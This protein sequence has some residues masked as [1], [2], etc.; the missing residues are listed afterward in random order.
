[1][2][3]RELTTYKYVIWGEGQVRG[4]IGPNRSSQ[5][6][7]RALRSVP[8]SRA[9]ASVDYLADTSIAGVVFLADRLGKPVLVE[10]PGRCRQDRARQGR[11]PRSPARG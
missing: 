7:G 11:R 10:G 1:M 9:C 6:H 5:L 2:G 3:L 8:M 4:V